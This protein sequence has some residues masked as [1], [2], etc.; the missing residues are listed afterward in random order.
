MHDK[1][2]FIVD[3]DE[4]NSGEVCLSAGHLDSHDLARGLVHHLVDGAIRPAANLPEVS[5]ILCREVT[6]LLRRDLQLP[7]RLDTVRPQTLSGGQR[8]RM[9]RD[10]TR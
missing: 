3:L 6:M 9:R 7:R 2:R 1:D 5:Q 10:W 8:M 4:L